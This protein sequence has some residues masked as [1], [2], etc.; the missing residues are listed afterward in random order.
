M[1]RETNQYAEKLNQ[2]N[3][4]GRVSVLKEIIIDES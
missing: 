1:V 4:K 2:E 3:H